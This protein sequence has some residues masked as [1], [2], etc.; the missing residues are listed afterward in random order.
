VLLD[1]MTCVRDGRLDEAE[2]LLGELLAEQPQQPDALHLLGVCRHERND[3]ESAQRLIREAIRSW[4]AGD[5]QICVPWNNLGNV[6]VES[7]QPDDAVEAYRAALAA[8][9]EAAG[10][11]TNLAS[12]LRRLG[13]LDEAERAARRAVAAATG[14]P[15]AHFTLARVLIEAGDVHGG[16]Q[17]HA[18]GVTLAPRDVVGREEVL[19][20]LAVLGHRDEAAVLWGEWL[21]E[22][23]DDPVAQHHHAASVGRP[24]PRATNAYVATV[25]DDFAASFDAKLT[26][27][28]YRAP[29]LV[30]QALTELL[31]ESDWG[32]VVDLGCGTG[33]V[34]SL[35]RPRTGRLVGVDLSTGMLE[36]ARRR[37]VYDELVRAE[38]VS[39]LHGRQ[40]S[41]DVVVAADVLCYFGVLDDVISAAAA[42]LRPGGVLAFTVEALDTEQGDGPDGRSADWSLALTGR[43]AHAP[44]YV[45][46]AMTAFDDVAIE[47]CELRTEAGRPVAGLLVVGRTPRT[48]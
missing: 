29:E 3:P 34:G 30:V 16:L 8:Q 40:A 7:G 22:R 44:R 41:F 9:P 42:A 6:L 13:R 14:D 38:L 47:R 27:L 36:R 39:F 20:S 43:Y 46:D 12:L 5:P 32:T 4:P 11:W 17:A 26:K 33:L 45:A 21:R 35:L 10:T 2:S 37:R 19:R 28:Q 48:P 24:P 1:A 15:H 31:D 23:P 25:F 18:L